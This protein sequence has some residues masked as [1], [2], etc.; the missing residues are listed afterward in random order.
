[1]SNSAG[2]GEDILRVEV[3]FDRALGQHDNLDAIAGQRSPSCA[4]MFSRP[5]NC[6]WPATTFVDFVS[7]KCVWVAG[8]NPLPTGMPQ[9]WD[10]PSRRHFVGC[11]RQVFGIGRPDDGRHGIGGRR[12]QLQDPV[13]P[14]LRNRNRSHANRDPDRLR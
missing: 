6:T 10:F 7:R 4:L 3:P 2:L 12:L 1:M 14:G 11:R 8:W 9:V 5:T 13:G